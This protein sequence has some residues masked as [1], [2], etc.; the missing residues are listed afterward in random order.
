MKKALIVGWGGT[1]IR[2]SL[3]VCNDKERKNMTMNLKGVVAL[4]NFI[5]HTRKITFCYFAVLA[6]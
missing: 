2:A 4:G 1:T 3:K 6:S 5:I